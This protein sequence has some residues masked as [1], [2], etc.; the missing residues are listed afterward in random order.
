MLGRYLGPAIDVGPAMTAKIMNGNLEFVHWSTHRGLKEY[1]WKNQS[2]ISLR[3]E[4]GSNIKDRFGTDISTDDYPDT[5][6][7]DTPLYPMYEDDTTDV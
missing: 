5:N 6:F 3:K 1:E 7:E 2:H 4:F